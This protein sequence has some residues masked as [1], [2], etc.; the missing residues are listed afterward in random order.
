M[1]KI[2]IASLSPTYAEKTVRLFNHVGVRARRVTLPRELAEEGCTAGVL[3]EG[4]GREE[5]LRLLQSRRLPFR[6]I[7]PL[8][9]EGIG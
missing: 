9:K 1:E 4:A 3:A 8:G 5:I 2:L 6:R 7:I